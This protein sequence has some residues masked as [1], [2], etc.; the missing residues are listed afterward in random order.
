MKTVIS[1]ITRNTLPRIVDL[2]AWRA[3]YQAARNAEPGQPVKH[4]PSPRSLLLNREAAIEHAIR[5]RCHVIQTSPCETAAAIACGLAK[6]R[7]GYS[8]ATAIQSGCKRAE[9]LAW[10]TIKPGGAA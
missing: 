1:I 6:F 5:N 9:A 2:S 4:T 7:A 8:A 10:G 3:K